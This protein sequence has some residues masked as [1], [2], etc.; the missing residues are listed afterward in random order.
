MYI[1]HL[2]LHFIDSSVLRLLDHYANGRENNSY[3][4]KRS[5]RPNL[6]LLYGRKRTSSYASVVLLIPSSTFLFPSGSLPVF[7]CR[8]WLLSIHPS[9]FY[10]WSD[11]Y[12]FFHQH[13]TH[14]APQTLATGKKN[15]SA[16]TVWALRCH[17]ACMKI[18]TW[19]FLTTFTMCLLLPDPHG[20]K[21]L[22]MRVY[23]SL[24]TFCT[25]TGFQNRLVKI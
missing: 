8:S 9:L 23:R 22:V 18:N 4:S 10:I 12:F 20:S 21:T 16:T 11:I 25:T 7:V 17:A 1:V 13:S 24:G 14:E 5:Q 2:F 6:R 15:L 3:L 19:P